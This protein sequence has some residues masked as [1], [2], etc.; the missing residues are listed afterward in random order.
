MRV[1]SVAYPL[2]PASLDAAGGAEQILALVE[3]GIVRSGHES[4]VVAT[5]GS[6]VEGELFSTPV[7]DGEITDELREKAQATHRALIEEVLNRNH[8][9]LVH[10][11][12]LDFHR[13]VPDTRVPMLAT[14]H[15]PIDW[16]PQ[17]IF[18][19]KNVV[20]N[21]VSQDQ[22]H[23]KPLSRALPVVENGVDIGRYRACVSCPRE[24]LLF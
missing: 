1:L 19:L 4:A 21:C 5:A 14:L 17:Q 22:A 20:L 15:L 16:Y 11:H 10:F 3:R 6:V 18:S 12:G 9:D 24:Y 23:S 13:Y 2:L 7:P 8:I